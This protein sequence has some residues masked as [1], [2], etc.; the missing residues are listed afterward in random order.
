MATNLPLAFP[1]SMVGYLSSVSTLATKAKKFLYHTNYP[2]ACKTVSPPRLDCSLY[3]CRD[4]L[5]MLGEHC[6]HFD[7]QVIISI[8]N[9]SEILSLPKSLLEIKTH[10]QVE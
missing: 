3:Y 2:D 9:H 4:S 10:P 8:S 1:L 6:A 5:Q 7:R